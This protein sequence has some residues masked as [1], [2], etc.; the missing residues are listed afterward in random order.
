MIKLKA[1]FKEK[2]KTTAS[3]VLNIIELIQD[4]KNKNGHLKK[5]VIQSTPS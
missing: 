5:Q 1:H 2:N 3:C 4:K